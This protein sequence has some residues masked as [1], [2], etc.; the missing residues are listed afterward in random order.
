MVTDP[1]DAVAELDRSVARDIERWIGAADVGFAAAERLAATLP[2]GAAEVADLVR[3]RRRMVEVE[4]RRFVWS[5]W[6][7]NADTVGTHL[8]VENVRSLAAVRREEVRA[9][10]ASRAWSAWVPRPALARRVRRWL[11][12]GRPD[13]RWEHVD[14]LVARSGASI[15]R[16]QR[17]LG[18]VGTLDALRRVTAVGGA[19]V[20]F[21][22][23]RIGVFALVTSLVG[24]A[25]SRALGGLGAR[26]AV[27]AALAGAAVTNLAVTPYLR[28]R[29]S[30]RLRRSVVALF[31][32]WAGLQVS[33]ALA[34]VAAMEAAVERHRA[35]VRD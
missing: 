29:L 6:T 19:V 9:W 35:R 3:S 25:A 21:L 1:G 17:T 24:Q 27:A 7:G 8:V 14:E 28:R 2:I 23:T 22:A 13:P 30:G 26:G 34:D 12:R 18:L 10:R 4:A 33:L 20:G 31:Q 5:L 16:A 11:R 32:Q 15:R